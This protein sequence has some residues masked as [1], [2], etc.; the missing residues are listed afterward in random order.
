MRDSPDE[1]ARILAESGSLTAR[2]FFRPREVRH[3]GVDQAAV[4][5]QPSQRETGVG[6]AFQQKG[7]ALAAWS[8]AGS[9]G[10]WVADRKRE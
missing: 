6:P 3:G 5:E 10:A 4:G 9:L 2:H 8:P 7:I 1:M